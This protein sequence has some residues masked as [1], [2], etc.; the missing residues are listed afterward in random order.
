MQLFCFLQQLCARVCD[1]SEAGGDTGAVQF[2]GFFF[3]CKRP[4]LGNIDQIYV[5][6]LML[7][8]PPLC[9]FDGAD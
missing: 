4:S 6:T 8:L 1:N 5:D 9:R 3:L 2:L 7:R